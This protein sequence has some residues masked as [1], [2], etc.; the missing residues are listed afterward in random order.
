MC[1]AARTDYSTVVSTAVSDRW[2][3][4][5]GFGI[6]EDSGPMA[7]RDGRSCIMIIDTSSHSPRK[8]GTSERGCP[9]DRGRESWR[10][11]AL[12]LQVT[13][14][15]PQHRAYRLPLQAVRVGT[16]LRGGW[17]TRLGPS[18]PQG[19]RT[20]CFG[21]GGLPV[22]SSCEVTALQKPPG[23]G[24]LVRA[25]RF[26]RVS[27]RPFDRTETASARGH[28]LPTSALRGTG[29]LYPFSFTLFIANQ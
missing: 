14:G 23:V 29:H 21:S 1:C 2:R 19:P 4:R 6:R 20:V 10:V 24:R 3:S 22:Q 5:I 9:E 7:M 12:S 16:S 27:S 28:R 15:P 17:S 11:L 13:S 18:R 25:C 26:S 8:L